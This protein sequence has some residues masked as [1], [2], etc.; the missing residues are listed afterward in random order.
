MSLKH[1]R[2]GP[3]IAV[4]DMDRARE[5]YESGLDLG[6]QEEGQGEWVLYGCGEGSTLMVYLSPEHAGKSTATMAGW[7][8][9]DLDLEME[10]LRE[11]GIEFASYDQADGIR[12]DK[13][14]I[15]ESEEGMRVC[16]VQDPD[17]NTFAIN[18]GTE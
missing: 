4:T 9:D 3:T 18:Q 10:A 8:V 13:N 6:V 12:T 11:K 16:W 2:I 7:E 15:F 5:F 14:G 1:F 17:G